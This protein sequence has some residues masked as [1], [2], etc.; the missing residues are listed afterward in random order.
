M[1]RSDLPSWASDLAS[2]LPALV[3]LP[4]A[5]KA[6]HRHPRTLSRAAARGELEILAGSGG[7]AVVPRQSLVEWVAGWARAGA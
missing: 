1:K 6:V 7:R 3:P 5:A 4:D 2:G